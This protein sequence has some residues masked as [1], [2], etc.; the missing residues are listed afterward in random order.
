MLSRTELP[1]DKS[2]L[3]IVGEID[4]KVLP[5]GDIFIREGG[6]GKGTSWADAAGVGTLD[7]LLNARISED[8][9]FDGTTTAWRLGKRKIHI[10][11]GTYQLGDGVLP[12]LFAMGDSGIELIGGYYDGS[13][14]TDLSN[15]NPQTYPTVFTS[16]GAVRIAEVVGQKGGCLSLK[17]IP[18]KG[19]DTSSDGAALKVG[20]DGSLNLTDCI[21]SSNTTTG[22]G[23]GLYVS[24]GT[25]RLSGCRFEQNQAVST[26][27]SAAEESDTFL[28]E[29]SRGGAIFA[30]G[31]EADL[32]IDHCQ[33]RSN[34]AFVGADLELQNGADAFIYSSCFIGGLAQAGNH[35]K[36]YPGRSINA[37]AM[38]SGTTGALCICNSTFTKTSSAY[39]S[40]GGLPIVAPSNYYCMLV[41]CTLHDGAVASVRNNNLTSR[42]ATDP[43]LIWLISNLFVNSTGN[44]VNLGTA[45]VRH[46]FYNIM[47]KGNK[48]AL[49]N[50][51]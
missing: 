33:F 49:F 41:S 43:D 40:N 4:T 17:G 11:K 18:F 22:S 36:N 27:A 34:L 16:A 14:G 50:I 48:S 6:T 32:F 19:A 20:T 2:Q 7:K 30:V 26:I 10:A 15:N 39:T 38:P 51:S 12:F 8:I 47:E 42:T 45:S 1:L 25:I 9:R 35:F 13:T 44:A 3:R 37:D 24:K 23:A 29:T 5:D 46:G 28:Y 21:F 31:N